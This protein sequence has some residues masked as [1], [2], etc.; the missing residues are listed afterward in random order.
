[1]QNGAMHTGW[2]QPG[3]AVG[4]IWTH[5][6]AMLTGWGHILAMAGTTLVEM[7]PCTLAV[8]I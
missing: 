4:I 8:G 1:M 7:V 2:L 6:G 3:T 5:S